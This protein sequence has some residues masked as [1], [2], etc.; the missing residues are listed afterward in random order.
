[1]ERIVSLAISV[2]FLAGSASR[3]RAQT[4]PLE[5]F[6]GTYEYHGAVTLCAERNR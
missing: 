2:A 6:T 5:D 4:A 3:A 1:M